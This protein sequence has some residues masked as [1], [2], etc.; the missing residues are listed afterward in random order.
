MSAAL[1]IAFFALPLVLG[2]MVPRRYSL[3]AALAGAAAAALVWRGGISMHEPSSLLFLFGVPFSVGALVRAGVDQLSVPVRRACLIPGIVLALWA[4][5]F[6]PTPTNE[7]PMGPVSFQ[8][9]LGALVGMGIVVSVGW[10]EL[11]ALIRRKPVGAGVND[12]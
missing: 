3:Y 10:I 11:L 1:G 4:L 8:I 2:T 12:G 5:W 7:P 6:S 9:F